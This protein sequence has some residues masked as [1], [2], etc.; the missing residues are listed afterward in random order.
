[1]THWH[2]TDRGVQAP[3]PRSSDANTWQRYRTDD[4]LSLTPCTSPVLRAPGRA[5]NGLCEAMA[6]PFGWPG[7]TS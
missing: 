1:M 3:R 6:R 2:L 4:R 5:W 7:A